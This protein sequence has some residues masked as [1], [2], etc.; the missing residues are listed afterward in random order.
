MALF[1][2]SVCLYPWPKSMLTNDLDVI[3]IRLTMKVTQIDSFIHYHLHFH[4]RKGNNPILL[5]KLIVKARRHPVGY[6]LSRSQNFL[7]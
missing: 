2:D 1:D 5:D 4:F 3:E 6:I 7:W